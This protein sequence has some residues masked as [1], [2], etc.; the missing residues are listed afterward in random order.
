VW[1]IPCFEGELHLRRILQPSIEIIFC[2]RVF[3]GDYCKL[4]SYSFVKGIFGRQGIPS[5][6]FIEHLLG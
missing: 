5:N 6:L 2:G 4:I 1:P 3:G